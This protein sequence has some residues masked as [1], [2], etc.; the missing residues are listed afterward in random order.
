MEDQ[1]VSPP[2]APVVA[3]ANVAPGRSTCSTCGGGT[4]AAL[5]GQMQATVVGTVTAAFPSLSVEKEFAQSLGQRD[6][7]GFTDRETMH[8][9]LVKPENRYLARRMCFLHTP[10]GGGSS[11]AYVLLPEERDDLTVLVDTLKRSPSASEFDVAKGRI[12]GMAPP[13][14]CNAQ[15]LP[16]LAFS[17]LYSFR[18]ETH[19]KS[20][21]RSEKIPAKDFE[22]AS[23]ELF[24]RAMPM[25]SNATGATL[26]LTYAILSYAGLYELVAEKYSE[27]SSLAHIDVGQSQSNPERADIRLKFVKRDTGFTETYCFAVNYGGPFQYLEEL[28]HPCYEVSI[29]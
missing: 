6:F 27:N 3:P 28:L 19:I 21:P 5:S 7:K 12:V 2:I 15:Q 10:Y 8:A 9:V 11:P 4:P 24:H 17:Q 20:I 14:L 22:K 23:D 13:A 26:G 25:A 18:V 16:I 29:S 1:G